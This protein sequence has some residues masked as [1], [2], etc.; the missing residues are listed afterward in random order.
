M[1]QQMSLRKSFSTLREESVKMGS[2]NSIT[3]INLVV[4]F[5][6]FCVFSVHFN[7]V[8]RKINT[9]THCLLFCI[10]YLELMVLADSI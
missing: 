9:N 4:E 2:V 1:A 8:N 10:V 7:H 6:F 5:L 3:R